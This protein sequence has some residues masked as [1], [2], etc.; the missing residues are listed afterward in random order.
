MS[1]FGGADDWNDLEEMAK[2]SAV[3]KTSMGAENDKDV[4]LGITPLEYAGSITVSRAVLAA[5]LARGGRR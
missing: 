2:S 3:D 4:V 5:L 1:H